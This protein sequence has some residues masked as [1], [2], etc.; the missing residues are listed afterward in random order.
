MLLLTKYMEGKIVLSFLNVSLVHIFSVLLP[1]TYCVCSSHF[2]QRAMYML[3]Q[4][5][6][7]T[8]SDCT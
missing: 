6:Q 1:D 5:A 3:W 8:Y 4:I 2:V 7:I